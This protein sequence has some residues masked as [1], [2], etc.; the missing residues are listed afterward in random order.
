[1]LDP[2]VSLAPGPFPGIGMA[3]LDDVRDFDACRGVLTY[4]FRLVD[5]AQY[6]LLEG[7]VARDFSEEIYPN[8]PSLKSLAEM[9][10]NMKQVLGDN[11]FYRAHVNQSLLFKRLDPNT[12]SAT[13]ICFHYKADVGPIGADLPVPTASNA[14]Y[15]FIRANERE[16]WRLTRREHY[17]L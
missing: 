6:P 14:L 1:M 8:G 7:V 3:S 12:V 9:I 10:D 13:A 15:T 16:P 4:F 5:S 2:T 11:W 17:L